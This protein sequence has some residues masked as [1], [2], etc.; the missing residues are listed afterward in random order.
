MKNILDEKPDVELTGRLLASVQ[1]V[2]DSDV[3]GKDILNIG[4]GFGWCELNFL[5]RGVSQMTGIEIS[6]DDLKT[7]KENVV[8]NK[9]RFQIGNAIQ[10]PFPDQSFDTVVSWEVIEHIPKNTENMMF[11]EVYRVLKPGGA[12][13]LSTPY[14]TFFSD[15][16]DPAWWLVG[17]RHYSRERLISFA[18]RNVFAVDAVTIKGRWWTLF[19]ILNMYISKWILRRTPLFDSIFSRKEHAEYMEDDGFADIFVK[20][21]KK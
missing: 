21:K 16:L 10:L 14:H 5:N 2:E 12:F 19:S 6:E 7:A 4:C 15:I 13:Y 8:S 20:F 3:Q 1:F 18:T 9:V 17:H 11:K